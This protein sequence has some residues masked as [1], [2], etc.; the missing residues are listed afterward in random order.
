M[1]T[2]AS[3]D[4]NLNRVVVQERKFSKNIEQG[5]IYS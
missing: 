3:L 2:S 4:D 5:A 1:S